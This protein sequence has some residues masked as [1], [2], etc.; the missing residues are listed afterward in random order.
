MTIDTGTPLFS[1][2]GNNDPADDG[3]GSAVALPLPLLVARQWDFPLQ[4]YIVDGQHQ[5]AIQDWIAG[6]TSTENSRRVWSD[7]KRN[8]DLPELYE[9]I[10][11]LPYTV[12]NGRKYAMDFVG[13]K[14]LY[15]IAEYV[16]V[17][18]TD[19]LTAIRKYLADAGVFADTMRRDPQVR[20]QIA[21]A[22]IDED[23]EAVVGEVM[24]RVSDGYQRAGRSDSWIEVRV[25]GIVTRKQFTSALRAAVLNAPKH[26]YAQ[27]T[28]RLYKGLLDRTTAQLRGD[29]EITPKQNPRDHMG[30]YALAYIEMAERLCRDL[31]GETDT[32]LLSQALDIIWKVAQHI[33]IQYQATQD[34]LG[35]DLLTG[36]PLLPSGGNESSR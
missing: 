1:W 36:K 7:F 10:V 35:R 2:L 31:L 23:P 3:G 32:I 25:Q 17:R 8:N 4:Y 26:M 14:G 24:D 13:D 6:I 11:Q 33:K 18:D 5:Y 34:F 15:T 22:V 12:A 19:V 28:E 30:E 29:L 20:A 9:K 21:A 27:S 16:R